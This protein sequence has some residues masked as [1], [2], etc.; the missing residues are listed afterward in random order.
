M[1]KYR[2]CLQD[3]ERIDL[4]SKLSDRSLTVKTHK[5]IE[6]LL[7]LDQGLSMRTIEQK[8]G[9]TYPSLQLLSKRYSEC[10]LMCLKDS[11]R[12]GRPVN[13]TGEERAKLTALAC[14]EAPAGHARWTLRLLADKMVELE[15]CEHLSH[16]Q[17]GKILKKTNFNHIVNGNGVSA[18]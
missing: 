16:S 8:V 4:Q 2:I 10:Q 13:I 11:P 9:L 3:T 7:L 6:S 17:V 14:S 12:S 5:R 15:M 18:L 1:N